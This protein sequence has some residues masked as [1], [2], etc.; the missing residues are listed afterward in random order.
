MRERPSV[1]P[2]IEEIMTRE[3]VT[4][5]PEE[6]I[7]KAMD[8]LISQRLSGAPVVDGDGRVVGMLSKKDCLRAALNASYY[9]QWGGQVNDYMASPVET[10][11][12]NMDVIAA[13]THFLSS[14]FRR[15][16]VVREGRLVGQVSRLD[17]LRAL[18]RLWR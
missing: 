5:S 9:Q 15:F 12:P 17:L 1:L 3:V 10:L 16:P 8:L 13:A 4:L 2:S 18:A 7:L 11:D 14:T 6:E